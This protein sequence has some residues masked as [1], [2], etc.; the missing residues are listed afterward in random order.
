MAPFFGEIRTSATK[1]AIKSPKMKLIIAS[2]IEYINPALSIGINA[3]I[4][5]S[6]RRSSIKGSCDNSSIII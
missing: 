1:M 3:L 2:G 6:A 4:T 5:N